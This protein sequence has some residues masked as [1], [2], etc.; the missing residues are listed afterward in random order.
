MSLFYHIGKDENN[1]FSVA[2]FVGG[3]PSFWYAREWER[4]GAWCRCRCRWHV[5]VLSIGMEVFPW[6]RV[7]Q[8]GAGSVRVPADLRGA[9]KQ[10]AN[11]ASNTR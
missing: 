5:S 6:Q 8:A 2:C 10:K 11:S 3:V 4:L 7:R 1:D 9:L